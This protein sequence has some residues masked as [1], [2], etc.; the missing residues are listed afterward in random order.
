MLNLEINLI[1]RCHGQFRK[2]SWF[3]LLFHSTLQEGDGHHVNTSSNWKLAVSF[4]TR[5]SLSDFFLSI[6]FVRLWPTVVQHLCWPFLVGWKRL[7][8]GLEGGSC[9][10][11][12]K[13]TKSSLNVKNVEINN[14]G[15][16]LQCD[17]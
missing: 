9:F 1:N 13:L 16:K 5:Y 11:W 8:S 2:Q 15:V 14:Q 12:T 7:L 3:H 10:L 6:F 4:K 17:C